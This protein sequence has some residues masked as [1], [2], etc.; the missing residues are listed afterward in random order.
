MRQHVFVWNDHY[1]GYSTTPEIDWHY[2]RRGALCAERMFGYDGFPGQ[3]TF[4][5]ESFD[6][7]R[8]ITATLVGWTL[9]HIDFCGLLHAGNPALD[10]RNLITIVQDTDKVVGWLS[11]KLGVDR[12]R[13]KH[14]LSALVLGL[15]NQRAHVAELG[16]AF[17]PFILVTK[18]QVLKVM[19]GFLNEPFQFMVQ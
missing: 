7:Y 16:T 5:G 4:G 12:E 14:G 3:A 6:L 13:A 2:E 10:L 19:S 1:P 11:D 15:E 17:P 8:A 9:K 18:N